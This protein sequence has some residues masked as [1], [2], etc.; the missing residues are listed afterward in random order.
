MRPVPLSGCRLTP[1]AVARPSSFS[2]SSSPWLHGFSPL[3]RYYGMIRLLYQ[4]HPGVVAFTPGYLVAKDRQRS[5]GV[6]RCTFTA[7][8]PQYT[9]NPTEYRALWFPAH[10]PGSACLTRLH[11][12]SRI[13]FASGFLPTRPRG[14]AVALS[15]W[16]PS[17]GSTAVFHRLVHHHVQRTGPRVTQPSECGMAERALHMEPRHRGTPLDNTSPVPV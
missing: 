2:F 4:L 1:A 11:L 6:R 12:R 15:S 9:L 5:L 14:H 17:V 13:R 8:C 7:S 3:H 16:L 10:R